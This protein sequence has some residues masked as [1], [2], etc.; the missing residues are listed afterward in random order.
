[1]SAPIFIDF[2]AP[3][4]KKNALIVSDNTDMGGAAGYLDY[5]G[6]ARN[7]YASCAPF[8]SA[9]DTHL[10]HEIVLRN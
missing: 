7:G 8:T 2:L 4:L 10:G 6:D 1:M 3:A 5:I 9:L